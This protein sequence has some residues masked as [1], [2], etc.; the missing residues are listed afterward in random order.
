MKT[1]KYEY[2]GD[3][4]LTLNCDSETTH[5]LN[6]LE[7][8][9]LKSLARMSCRR[10]REEEEA[11]EEKR[12]KAGFCFYFFTGMVIFYSRSLSLL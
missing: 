11:E 9:S 6:V 3:K 8:L 5:K 12:S 10:A 4:I 2:I 1:Q 7:D